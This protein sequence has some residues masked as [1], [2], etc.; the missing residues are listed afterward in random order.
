MIDVLIVV[1]EVI[2]ALA[3]TLYATWLL[4]TR[5]IQG[6]SKTLS[7]REWLKHLFEAI[8]GL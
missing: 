3:I 8:W 4:I 6:E 1:A 2:V 7:F 5:L